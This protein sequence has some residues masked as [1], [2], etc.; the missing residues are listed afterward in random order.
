MSPRVIVSYLARRVKSMILRMAALS[1]MFLIVNLLMAL[2]FGVQ[3]EQ[4]EHLMGLT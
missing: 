4:L 3:R 1:T 2:S